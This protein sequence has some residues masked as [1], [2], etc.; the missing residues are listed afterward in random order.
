MDGAERQEKKGAAET[1]S[2]LVACPYCAED[3]KPEAKVCKHCGRDFFLIQPLLEQV[4]SLHKRVDELERGLSQFA[5]DTKQHVSRLAT[6]PAAAPMASGW[7]ENIPAISRK[8]AVS[9]SLIWV[10]V[11]DYLVNF[12]LDESLSYIQIAV[13]LGPI[14]CGFL[15]R[16]ETKRPLLANFVASILLAAVAVFAMSYLTAKIANQPMMP[17]NAEDWREIIQ[18]SLSILFAFMGGVFAR[19]LFGF[20]LR[21]PVSHDLTWDVSNYVVRWKLG[22][23]MRPA[24][25][26]DKIKS[27]ES[28]LTS[29]LAIG[30]TAVAILAALGKLVH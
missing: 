2:D 9:L 6:R 23:N 16:A 14:A 5:A 20:P 4:R 11:S 22:G 13:V 1:A 10:M 17:Q 29:L 19:R 7:A 24:D 27:V 30:T 21:Q 3:I 28:M 15:C 26:E 18:F 25:I 12:V 8:L